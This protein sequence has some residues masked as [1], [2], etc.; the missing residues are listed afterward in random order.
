MSGTQPLPSS[1]S[2][3]TASP[4]LP[5]S[6]RVGDGPRHEAGAGRG[7]LSTPGLV[8]EDGP[9]AQYVVVAAPAAAARVEPWVQDGEAAGRAPRRRAEGRPVA[10]AAEAVDRRGPAAGWER[11]RG[12]AGAR[13]QAWRR[14]ARGHARH[15]GPPPDAWTTAWTAPS[16]PAPD[17]EG[18]QARPHAEGPARPRPP[19]AAA[20]SAGDAVEPAEEP[21]AE[22]GGVAGP[23]NAPEAAW[24]GKRPN[25]VSQSA[26]GGTTKGLA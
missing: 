20:Q 2:L 17:A 19:A 10:A 18:P 25:R 6:G 26:A 23:P 8:L 9:H 11:K 14:P 3:P 16:T 13:R 22:K 15:V 5:P 12:P 4:R 1:P 7:S 24:A 21:A